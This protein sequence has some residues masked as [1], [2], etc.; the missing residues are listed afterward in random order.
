MDRDPQIRHLEAIQ[1]VINR[2]AQ[3]SL[4]SKMSVTFVA[5]FALA[6][7][8]SFRFFSSPSA[9]IFWISRLFSASRKT[10]QCSVIASGRRPSSDFSDGYQA[11][12]SLHGPLFCVTLL[13]PPIFHG[14]ILR[15]SPQDDFVGRGACSNG[16]KLRRSSMA[17]KPVF[18]SFHFDNDVMR[19]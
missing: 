5:R 19:V 2:M 10:L 14:A 12:S 16:R 7:A 15:P 13:Y 6:A 11:R 17:R 8:K 1:G 4:R 9:C 3:N 18:Y